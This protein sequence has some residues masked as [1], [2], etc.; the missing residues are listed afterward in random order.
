MSKKT[1]ATETEVGSVHGLV[2]ELFLDKLNAIKT[3]H[4]G[5]D[6]EDRIYT[7]ETKD[8]LAAAKWVQQNEVVCSN[9]DSEEQSEIAQKLEELREKSQGN[10]LTFER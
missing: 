8:L 6:E 3:K 5:A 10:V 4:D 9:D 7:I 2:N 1:V